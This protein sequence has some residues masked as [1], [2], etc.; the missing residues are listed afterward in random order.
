MQGGR[1]DDDVGYDEDD[2][3]DV[4]AGEEDD[5]D[6]SCGSDDDYDINDHGQPYWAQPFL[7]GTPGVKDG[8]QLESAETRENSTQGRIIC[9]GS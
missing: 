8:A 6:E 5:D 3:D 2:A 9:R 1:D 4:V 7:L